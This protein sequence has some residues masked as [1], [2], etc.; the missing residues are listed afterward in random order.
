[1]SRKAPKSINL[2]ATG[3]NG[4][5]DLGQDIIMKGDKFHYQQ[6][7]GE[8]T[9]TE[10][11]RGDEKKD[12][13]K[14][15]K[16]EEKKDEK[17]GD[18]KKAEKKDEKKGDEKKDGEKKDDK[19]EE[20]KDDK[21]DEKADEKKDEKKED[22]KDEKKDGEEKEEEEKKEEEKKT[23]PGEATWEEHND[24]KENE[25]EAPDGNCA[26]EGEAVK[27]KNHNYLQVGG[28]QGIAKD[29]PT[30]FVMKRPEYN[31]E[32]YPDTEK[33]HTLSP[34]VHMEYSNQ[35]STYLYPRTAFYVDVGE[36]EGLWMNADPPKQVESVRGPSNGAPLGQSVHD[37]SIEG[38]E[39]Y[40]AIHTEPEPAR[41]VQHQ[42][43][44]H[45][46]EGRA[47][48]DA[49]AKASAPT[50][51]PGVRAADAPTATTIPTG[52]FKE[53]DEDKKKSSLVQ[54]RAPI[55][56]NGSCPT[57]DQ[58]VASAVNPEG[59]GALHGLVND[60]N[61]YAYGNRAAE[62]ERG[63]QHQPVSYEP[64]QGAEQ[65]KGKT[66]EQA[67]KAT[68]GAGKDAAPAA[69]AEK[70]AVQIFG[71]E[72][73]EHK[74]I[75]A[76]RSPAAGAPVG[77]AVWDLST[78][79]GEPYAKVHTVEA[80]ERHIQHQPVLWR[81]EDRAARYAKITTVNPGITA[82]QALD[83]KLSKTIGTGDIIEPEEKETKP[84]GMD[85]LSDT[86][87]PKSQPAASLSQIQ[88]V[89]KRKDIS[90]KNIDEEVWGFV[91]ADKNTL[92][93]P[94]RRVLEPYPANG[95]LNPAGRFSAPGSSS[96][97]QDDSKKKDISDKNID[98]EVWG[99]V[100]ADKNTL[101]WQQR[102]V[103]EPYPA[104]G[105]LNPAGRFSLSQDSNRK[106]DIGDKNIDEEVWGLVN[107]DKNTLPW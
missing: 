83:P 28:P 85:K 79:G 50:K 101:P 42:P 80:P 51:N 26:F 53:T 24:C 23:G 82:S 55:D 1:M 64:A 5:E 102:R 48:R 7:L 54:R 87:R 106:K 107:A 94:H 47:A 90:D 61:V 76:I 92:P 69:P 21:K 98:E 58:T 86:Q 56:C 6:N 32:G 9:I 19:K 74:G 12:E 91:N 36:G 77:Q 68:T 88:D 75:S 70:A 31:R 73:N 84:A 49:A 100:N 17:K 62:P 34:E 45:D 40:A 60:V 43:F 52:P 99:F 72:E 8:M 46:E 89:Q 35:S 13:K 63:P 95:W 30:P 105:W 38:G 103:L 67:A 18:E 81:E 37:I 20:K 33:V 29:D 97:A 3:M 96:L 22:G 27:I 39:P 10:H 71:D 65:P 15:D 25:W 11:V 104:N 16:K 41:H 59:M 66:F 78:E 44:M 4:D 14:D 93:W 57:N 2:F